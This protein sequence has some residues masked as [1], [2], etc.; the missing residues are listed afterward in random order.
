MMRVAYSVNH[1]SEHAFFNITHEAATYQSYIK[2]NFAAAKLPR[3]V[4]AQVLF[5]NLGAVTLV[6]VG[7]N[8]A[9]LV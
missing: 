3:H 2:S 4:H 7:I 1:A 6:V 8:L 9:I 5:S